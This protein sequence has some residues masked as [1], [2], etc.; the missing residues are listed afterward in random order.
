M[1]FDYFTAHFFVVSR[2]AR[3]NHAERSTRHQAYS[4]SYSADG[5]S[6]DVCSAWRCWN[7]SVMA[8]GCRCADIPLPRPTARYWTTAT[9][10]YLDYQTVHWTF[11]RGSKTH[12]LICQLKPCDHISSSSLHWLPIRYRVQYKLCTVMYTIHHGL[13]PAYLSEQINTVAAQ[14]LRR[15]LRSTST[16]L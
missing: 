5:R 16:I 15:G 2:F 10:C 14:T 11:C 4:Y 12:H 9:H 1:H 8:F 3:R 7:S 13:S 6:V